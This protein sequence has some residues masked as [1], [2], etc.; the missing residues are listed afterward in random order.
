[1][2]RHLTANFRESIKTKKHKPTCQSHTSRQTFADNINIYE[3]DISVTVHH[4][5]K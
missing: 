2:F 5:Y 3:L 4:I 1:M